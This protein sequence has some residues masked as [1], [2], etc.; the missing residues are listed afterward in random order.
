MSVREDVG[1]INSSLTFINDLLRSM[2]DS[3][4][5]ANKQMK[6]EK[7]PADVLKDILQPIAAILYRRDSDF[8]V[9]TDCP[10]CRQTAPHSPA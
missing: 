3:H 8:V 7:A 10:A 6:I 1:V 2:L 9:Q 5:A 4:R